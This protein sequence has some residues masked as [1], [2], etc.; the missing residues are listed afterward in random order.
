MRWR[1]GRSSGCVARRFPLVKLCCGDHGS[2]LRPLLR[3]IPRPSAGV[4]HIATSRATPPALRLG[5]EFGLCL[6]HAFITPRPARGANRSDSAAGVRG[7]PAASSPRRGALPGQ[8][9]VQLR[10][11][12]PRNLFAIPWRRGPWRAA[13]APFYRLEHS[14]NCSTGGGPVLTSAR[15]EARSLLRPYRTSTSCNRKWPCPGEGD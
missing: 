5:R 11:A 3:T 6:G 8:L 9:I 14:R 2:A 7:S 13:P 4:A 1:S 10:E 12:L 15:R